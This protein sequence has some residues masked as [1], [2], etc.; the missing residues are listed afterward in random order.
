MVNAVIELHDLNKNAVAVIPLGEAKIKL[1]YIKIIQPIDLLKMYEII[2]N[3]DT[4]VKNNT[5]NSQ[6]YRLLNARNNLLYQTYL[7]L[8]PLQ[9][10]TKRWDNLGRIIKWIAGTPDADD[11]RVINETMNNLIENNNQ[12]IFFNEST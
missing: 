10:R 9:H 3:F 6:L 1:G 8:I 11:L 2:M 7:K 12:Q 4:L 5:Y